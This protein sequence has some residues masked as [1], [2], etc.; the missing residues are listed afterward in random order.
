MAILSN[1]YVDHVH[2][3]VFDQRRLHL[4]AAPCQEN[5]ST[6]YRMEAWTAAS[7]GLPSLHPVRLSIKIGGKKFAKNAPL[8]WH[9][10]TA[11]QRHT[12]P[13]RQRSRSPRMRQLCRMSLRHT[14]PVGKVK[15]THRWI[16]VL[17]W[18]E[19]WPSG[20]ERRVGQSIRCV[21]VGHAIFIRFHAFQ[22]LLCRAMLHCPRMT[23]DVY[24]TDYTPTSD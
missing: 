1:I 21:C 19:I 2:A 7:C 8:I 12:P 10:T 4:H 13:K 14:I 24:C 11:L 17:R 22:F 6:L 20:G 18:I 23:A 15:N 3:F 16:K 9:L 5:K